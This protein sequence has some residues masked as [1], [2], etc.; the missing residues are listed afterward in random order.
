MMM[1]KAKFQEPTISVDRNQ[2]QLNTTLLP[3]DESRD[4]K[5]GKL[6]LRWFMDENSKL[7]SQWIIE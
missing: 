1:S 4:N 3:L 5:K 6:V 7:Y 2:E